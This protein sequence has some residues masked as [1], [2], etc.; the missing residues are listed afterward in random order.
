MSLSLLIFIDVFQR[1]GYH[2]N[3][4]INRGFTITQTFSLTKNLSYETQKFSM[5]SRTVVLTLQPWATASEFTYVNCRVNIRHK[6]KDTQNLG[7]LNL[8]KIEHVLKNSLFKFTQIKT[9]MQIVNLR[10]RK[11]LGC[12]L[13]TRGLVQSQL[14]RLQF[15]RFATRCLAARNSQTCN[16]FTQNLQFVGSHSSDALRNQTSN[17]KYLPELI[18]R[19]SKV[20]QRICHVEVF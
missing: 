17:R 10:T 1:S 16:S 12:W 4:G 14:V 18:E 7:I 13:A 3:S 5:I 8:G 15:D 20:Y 2:S 11:S 6:P 9:S 19:R